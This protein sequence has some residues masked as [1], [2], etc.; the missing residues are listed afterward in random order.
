MLRRDAGKSISFCDDFRKRDFFQLGRALLP[1]LAVMLLATPQLAFAQGSL[2]VTVHPRTLEIAEGD[3]TG[4]TYTVVL[5]AE[6]AKDVT[7]TVV[8]AATDSGREL[9]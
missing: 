5:D 9:E 3:V 4:G 2:A 1:F 6:P 7:V 8:G